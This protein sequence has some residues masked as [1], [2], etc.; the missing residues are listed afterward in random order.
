[1]SGVLPAFFMIH[2][3]EMKNSEQATCWYAFRLTN[4][5]NKG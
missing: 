5:K 2:F 1:M 3:G 4:I